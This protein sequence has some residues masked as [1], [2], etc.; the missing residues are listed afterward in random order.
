MQRLATAPRAYVLRTPPEAMARHARLLDPPP[1]RLRIETTSATT[2]R[3]WV[4]V[5]CRDQP[6]LLASITQAFAGQ[7]LTIS[8]AVLAVWEDDVVLDAFLVEPTESL[9]ESA[10]TEAI[11]AALDGPLSSPPL[12]DAEV[13]FD[14]SASPW[15][16]LCEVVL[17]DRLGV[18]HAVAAAFAGAGIE[19]RAAQVTSHDGLVIDRFDV[20]DRDG[21]KLTPELEERFRELLRRG[22]SA[23]RRRF[24]RRLAVRAATS[25]S[26]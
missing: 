8:D 10:L 15:H 17:A 7:G 6:G 26:A 18:L 14:G 9:D 25:N 20:T 2:G 11:A 12:P 23:K 4:D 24:S 16:T 19:V 13:T 21:A 3:A 1:H 5:A 22:V